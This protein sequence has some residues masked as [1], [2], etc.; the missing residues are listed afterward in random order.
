MEQQTESSTGLIAVSLAPKE[1]NYPNSRLT[2]YKA[3]PDVPD[4][5]ERRRR[6]LEEQKQ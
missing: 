6:F 4:Q 2:Q 1:V 5:Q 3:R